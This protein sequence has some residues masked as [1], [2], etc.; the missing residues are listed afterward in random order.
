MRFFRSALLLLFVMAAGTAAAQLRQVYVDLS[1]T[2]NNISKLSFFGPA[3]GYIASSGAPDWIGYTTDSGHSFVRK[4]ITLTNVDFNGYPVNLT[5]GF[6]VNGVHAFSQD[7]VIAYGDYGLVPAILYSVD[8]G[9]T[10]KLVYHSQFNNFQLRTGVMDM[11]FPGGGSTGIA[12]DADRI[13]RSTD[14]GKTWSTAQVTAGLYLEHLEAPDANTVIAFNKVYGDS[15]AFRST[16]GGQFFSAL[17]I[18]NNNNSTSKLGYIHFLT[19]QKGWMSVYNYNQ[20]GL[21]YYT[22]NGGSSWT[23]QNNE[24]VT[25][26][27]GGKFEFVNDSTGYALYMYDVYRTSDSGKVW[28]PLPRDNNFSYL[29][30]GNNDVQCLTP[31]QFWV[32]GGRDH[33]QLSTNGGGTPLPRAA[34]T[35]DTLGVLSTGIVRLQNYSKRFYTSRWI[36]NGT[37]VSTS[38]NT[39]YSHAVARSSDTVQ[40]IVSNGQKAD[41]LQQILYFYVPPIPFITVFSPA[42]G[43]TG[44]RVRIQGDNFNTVT[45]VRFGG[46][47][48]TSFT[49]LNNNTIDAIVAGGS[50]GNVSLVNAY[51]T[52]SA[53]GFTYIAP[54]SAAAPVVTALSPASGPVGTQV[55]LTGNNFAPTPAGNIVYFGGMKATVS[56]ATATQ[57]VC[58]VPVSASFGPITVLNTLNGLQTRT[59]KR[60]AVTRP[61]SSNFNTQS[62]RYAYGFSFPYPI[63]SK[64]AAAGDVDGDG[65]PDLLTLKSSPDSLFVYRNRSTGGNFDFAPPVFIRKS[66]AFNFGDLYLRDVDGDGRQDL[67]SPTNS[68]SVL[69]FRNNST[70]GTI[71]FDEPLN[72]GT[73]T[74]THGTDAIDLDGDGR[75]ELAIACFSDSRLSVL[76]NTSAPGRISFGAPGNF[77]LPG[78]GV[79]LATDDMDGDGKPDVVVMSDNSLVTVV[80][81]FRNTSTTGN[82]GFATRLDL[83]GINDWT[84][85]GRTINV[86]DFDGDG[87]KDIILNG[88]DSI[89][90]FRN[91]STAGALSFAR[92]FH[93]NDARSFNRGLVEN[94]S[95]DSK[96]DLAVCSWGGRTLFLVRNTSTPGQIS[97]DPTVSITEP[98]PNNTAMYDI[99]AADFN[100]DGHIDIGVSSPEQR[101]SIFTNNLNG[102]DERELCVNGYAE[103]LSDLT[104]T[105]YQWQVDSGS[106][107]ANVPASATV[108]GTAAR[109]LTITRFPATWGGARF[110]CLV[111]GSR[112]SARTRFALRTYP[113]PAV[114][115]SASATTACSGSNVT[116]T[117][118]GSNWGSNPFI[119]WFVDG[120]YVSTGSPVF[121]S[122]SLGNGAIIQAQITNNDSFRCTSYSRDTSLRIV[123]TI[124]PTQPLAATITGNTTVAPGNSTLI[125]A[126][127]VNGGTSPAYQWSDST[128]ATGWHDIGGATA[129]SVTYAPA[130]NGARLR[131]RVTSNATCASPATVY[132]NTLTFIVGSTT[133][134][135]GIP[136]AEYGISWYPVPARTQL[137]MSGLRLSDKWE[138]LK[139]LSA[140]GCTILIR[141]ITGQRSLIL[142]LSGLPAGEYLILLQG[143]GS[144]ARFRIVH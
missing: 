99:C 28:E 51:G 72:L 115:V 3:K 54:P 138:H 133:A 108:T 32:G 135:P 107:Y 127:Q 43:S 30:Y 134:L 75:P 118:S 121:S 95:G 94:L 65:K 86:A 39:T 24:L 102:V 45:S 7:T 6:T 97:V 85:N 77:V 10:F 93:V 17:T 31:Q 112:Y 129:A 57:I 40:L 56:A 4:P 55:T 20:N 1:T 144:E 110:R 64:G 114:T 74:S 73:P 123:M 98:Y 62:F 106:G 58:Q 101:F 119:Q 131:C 120:N 33:L 111:D 128:S 23:L 11:I 89:T 53:P 91:T 16:N 143:R 63:G 35:A 46:L 132:S 142:P 80:S 137:N 59:E 88:S 116:F 100:L 76:R 90:I 81:V 141:N 8:G 126:A 78:P 22:G 83:P 109:T 50:S 104:G 67:I 12:V 139:L 136:A 130:V 44:T 79:G 2:D 26:F 61:D 82:I 41:T 25:P 124:N 13:L 37:Q 103:L 9:N 15:R 52:I 21:V 84:G 36:V 69:V 105:S 18:P 60:F 19:A 140:D 42:S 96:P 70:P 113:V 47:S 14:R 125:S 49:I 66:L 68:D 27:H 92:A 117:A 87:K 5:F 38:Y 34:F 71:A 29:G 48:A 122:S